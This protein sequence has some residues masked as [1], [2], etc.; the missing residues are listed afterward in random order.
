MTKKCSQRVAVET[1]LQEGDRIVLQTTEA[2]FC[3]KWGVARCS[4]PTC[5]LPVCARHRKHSHKH[6]PRNDI[7]A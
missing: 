4:K 1:F 6:E 5:K 3:G 2:D 7:Y